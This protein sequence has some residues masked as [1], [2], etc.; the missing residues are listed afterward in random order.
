MIEFR[1]AAKTDVGLVRT[2]NEDNFQVAS[3][4]SQRQMRWINNEV[5]QLG[6]KG[7]LLVVADGMG[8]M[9]AGEVASELAIE[10]VREWFAPE[11]I[12][13]EVVKSRYSMERFMNDAIVAADA[14]I[15][16]EA[17][18]NPEAHGMGTTIVIGWVFDGKLYV[19]WCG[20]SRAYIYNPAAGLHQVSKDHSYVQSLVDSGKI[21]R[22]D[23]FDFPDSN[24]ITRSLSDATSKAKP[25]SLLKPHDLADGDIVL[26]CTDGLSGMIREAEMEQVIRQHEDNM[27][28]LANGLIQAAC[29]AEGSDNVTLCLCQVLSG[30]VKCDPSVY[31]ATER[32]LNGGQKAAPLT[33]TVVGSPQETTGDNEDEGHS[34]HGKALI[35]GTALCVLLAAGAGAWWYI[36]KDGKAHS[37][38]P[39][40]PAA[41]SDT[42]K[43]APVETDDPQAPAGNA[44]KT[45]K[46]NGK[47]AKK[48]AKS[49]KAKE[50]KDGKTPEDKNE[51][52]QEETPQDEITPAGNTPKTEGQEANHFILTRVSIK[53]TVK[54]GET[55]SGIAKKYGVTEAE[56]LD[57]NKKKDDKI[58][59]GEE[60]M[61]PQKKKN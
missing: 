45:S 10:T 52:P 6:R 33:A 34:K 18:A 7:A 27:D 26:L 29:D 48:D 1:L 49:A 61:I 41:P 23:A 30:G 55:L 2:N 19:S 20:D 43:T 46:E 4:L 3:D 57:F 56:I 31:E 53:H 42:T 50:N 40:P 35:L 58:K 51:A 59:E 22:E 9:N 5:C 24:I 14:N 16:R 25:E 21:S 32:R 60:L 17:K 8:G 36:S 47:A 12:T 39:A 44:A 15:K 13:D 37:E 28:D 11:R 38:Q 54:K